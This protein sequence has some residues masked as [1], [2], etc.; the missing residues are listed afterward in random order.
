MTEDG[1][2]LF[3]R[4]YDK[5]LDAQLFGSLLSALHSFAESLTEGGLSNFELSDKRYAI[6]KKNKLLFVANASLKIKDKKLRDE[7]QKVSTTFFNKYNE[8]IIED[9]DNDISIF[10]DF[11]KYIE[12]TL[13]NPMKKFW[14]GF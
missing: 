12:D 13:E 10:L 11:E 1:I 5:K 8:S 4:V 7:I 2:V 3:S 9:W 6:M 14:N